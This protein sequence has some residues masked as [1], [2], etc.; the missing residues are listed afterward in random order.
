MKESR[1]RKRQEMRFLQREATWLQK[2]LFALGKADE[3]HEKLAEG[4]A[5]DEYALEVG[6]RSVPVGDIEDGLQDRV[7]VLLDKVRE[8]RREAR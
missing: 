2:A 7:K 8:L 4:D 6:G 3:A 1:R 5:S